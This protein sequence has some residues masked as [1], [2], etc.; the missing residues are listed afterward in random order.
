MD[1]PISA[2]GK[3]LS[4]D[5]LYFVAKNAYERLKVFSSSTSGG[6]DDALVVLLF[7]A[8]AL[9]A[10]LNEL[11]EL[12]SMF[13]APSASEPP[14]IASYVDLA[15]EVE[16]N[17]G[18]TKLKYLIAY[19][20]LSGQPCKKGES[21]Y[22]DFSL[23]VDIRN[24]LLHAKPRNVSSKTKPDGTIEFGPQHKILAR[25]RDKDI[26]DTSQPTF[27]IPV[28]NPQ[29]AIVTRPTPIPLP[30]HHRVATRAAANWACETVAT[31]VE[32]LL[33]VVPN[34]QN[35]ANVQVLC[36]SFRHTP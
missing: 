21:P 27:D 6:K 36:Q 18:S 31:V 14:Q 24:E 26:L 33:K 29:G 25:L 28:T 22:Q 9:E 34:S 17:N 8:A 10:F 30:W 7:C 20:I 1:V 12:L 13:P 3:L 2:Q 32:S 11:P 16:A 23:L 4:A 35:K 15:E 19:S 5:R